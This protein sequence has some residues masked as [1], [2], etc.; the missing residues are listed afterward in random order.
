MNIHS[1]SP[2]EAPVDSANNLAESVLE[3]I[4]DIQ[5]IGNFK[6]EGCRALATKLAVLNPEALVT[7]RALLFDTKGSI[8]VLGN[9]NDSS[10][11][12]SYEVPG[13]KVTESLTDYHDFNEAS[14]TERVKKILENVLDE[15]AEETQLFLYDGVFRFQGS[16]EKELDKP[17]FLKEDRHYFSTPLKQ[18]QVFWFSGALPPLYQERVRTGQMVDENGNQ[19]DVHDGF[20]TIPAKDYER[21]SDLMALNSEIPPELQSCLVEVSHRTVADQV[22]RVIDSDYPNKTKLNFNDKS[23]LRPRHIRRLIQSSRYFYN[24]ET[25]EL[26]LDG[27]KIVGTRAMNCVR[28]YWGVDISEKVSEAFYGIRTLADGVSFVGAREFNKEED[29]ETIRLILVALDTYGILASKGFLRDDLE[30]MATDF[31]ERY[32]S[33]FSFKPATKTEKEETNV[34]WKNY[35]KYIFVDQSG[36]SHSVFVR[37]N[38]KAEERIVNKYITKPTLSADSDI[39]DLLGLRFVFADQKAVEAFN[40]WLDKRNIK[41]KLSIKRDQEEGTNIEGSERSGRGEIKYIGHHA[42]LPCEVQIVPQSLHKEDEKGLKHHSNYRAKQMMQGSGRIGNLS[43]LANNRIEERIRV[44]SEEIKVKP[45]DTWTDWRL[46]FFKGP[47]ETW[48]SY[49][50][51]FAALNTPGLIK[52]QDAVL[53]SFFMVLNSQ[54]GISQQ[55]MTTADWYHLFN[56]PTSFCSNPNNRYRIK[57][58]YPRIAKLKAQHLQKIVIPIMES[59]LETDNPQKN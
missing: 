8:L 14:L 3:K 21:N 22:Y 47:N 32:L 38:A 41:T 17:Y 36:K 1:I 30:V 29:R 39:K 7:T 42:D 12:P 27:L 20:A 25:K 24:A 45:A 44:L 6:F 18:R 43:K 46:S 51:A 56:A 5:I 48:F 49:E 34:L 9:N 58:I 37:K 10:R 57:Q 28:N 54:C 4:E 15:I 40:S 26:N 59:T 2:K 23:F 52:N 33:E 19:E 31:R 50:N 55:E 13:G 16:V 11:G 53:K 35:D